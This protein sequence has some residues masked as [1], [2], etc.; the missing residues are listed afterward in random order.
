MDR[1][2]ERPEVKDREV[3]LYVFMYGEGEPLPP[4]LSTSCL[5]LSFLGG[6][7]SY[8]VGSIDGCGTENCTKANLYQ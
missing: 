7:S 6:I 1:Q 3:V 8:T 2:E 5:S 4:C